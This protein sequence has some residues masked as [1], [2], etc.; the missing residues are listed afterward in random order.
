MF[1]LKLISKDFNQTH[2]S[3][4][5]WQ[6]FSSL[7]KELIK[8]LSNTLLNNW[9]VHSVPDLQY[10]KLISHRNQKPHWD[11]EKKRRHDGKK[12]KQESRL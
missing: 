1:L 12:K 5:E 2:W 10:S 8:S 4:S 3:R 9:R 7:H 11:A 6:Q